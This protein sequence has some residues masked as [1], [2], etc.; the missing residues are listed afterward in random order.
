M[1]LNRIDLKLGGTI[2]ALFLALLFPLGFVIH[3]IFSGFYFNTVEENTQQISSQYASLIASNHDKGIFEVLNLM[4]ALS[5][6]LLYVVDDSGNVVVS[7]VKY[8]QVGDKI[9]TEE[10]ANL[11]KGLIQENIYDE[12][13]HKTYYI[14]G[15]SI[16]LDN[17]F[18]GAVYILTPI[19]GVIASLEKIRRLIFFAALGSFFLA[20][21]F[22]LILSK[23]LSYPLIQM[24]QVTRRIAKGNL[25]TKLQVSS[26][27]EIGSLGEAIN[28]LAEDLRRY[29]NGRNE[30]FANISHELRT[31]L[32][33]IKG[34][35]RVLKEELYKSNEEKNQYLN[36]IDNET[37]RL[38]NL[39]SD[40]SDLSMIEEGKINLN[41]VFIDVSEL[42]EEV[43]LKTKFRAQEKGL[44]Y[45]LE[46]PSEPPLILGDELR[47][48]QIF[49][50]LIEN[51]I[52]YTDSGKVSIEIVTK[53]KVVK[54][55]IMDTGVGISAE[56]LPFIF[57]RFYRVEKSRSRKYGG[58]GLGLSIV[59]RLVELQN[60]TITIKSKLNVGTTVVVTFPLSTKEGER[61]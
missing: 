8:T 58:S 11:K 30:F 15:S 7:N 61:M 42:V 43:Y 22:T 39:I 57:E 20:I 51:A 36:I 52:R 54:I 18:L 2:T 19:E 14:S 37:T 48:E 59:K 17:K 31:P 41:N 50:N 10:L 5:Q 23:K 28:D 33:Y 56:D 47:L 9:S 26:K 16:F 44:G 6:N 38:T 35:S 40:L 21:G 25:D 13:H 3:E 29:R 53:Q 60:G 12:T 49:I 45:T 1:N 4:A 46:K 24:E 55:V 27:D 34:Y 32:T